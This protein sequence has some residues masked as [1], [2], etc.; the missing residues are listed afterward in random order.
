MVLL[1]NVS[2]LTH[3]TPHV[4]PPPLFCYNATV[5]SIEQ[6]VPAISNL[7]PQD[8]LFVALVASGWPYTKAA[9]KCGWEST[10]GWKRMQAPII[11][12]AVTELAIQ[13]PDEVLRVELGAEL[14][15]IRRRLAEGDVDAAELAVIDT[16]VRTIMT[17]AKYAGVYVDKKQ[18]DKRVIDL[19]LVSAAALNQH[20][21]AALDVL[22]PGERRAIEER[23][24]AVANSRSKSRKSASKMSK[25]VQ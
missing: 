5:T 11:R 13:S 20:L 22:E 4:T 8:E 6:P 9:V 12:Q 24:R 16:R 7:S 15:M 21:G 10:Y 2:P 25:D 1:E 19:S 23:V 3:A 17:Q 18:V 14:T